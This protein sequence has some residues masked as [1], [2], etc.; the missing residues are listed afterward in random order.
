MKRREWHLRKSKRRIF[1]LL[2][3]GGVEKKNKIFPRWLHWQ[4]WSRAKRLLNLIQSTSVFFSWRFRK[5]VVHASDYNWILEWYRAWKFNVIIETRSY[6]TLRFPV[7]NSSFL[8]SCDVFMHNSCLYS[9]RM[10]IV[11]CVCT[12]NEYI[13]KTVFSIHMY[14]QMYTATLNNIGY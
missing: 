4:T 5:D 13:I 1:R 6:F 8:R 3:W 7:S 14:I 12:R 10:Y 11:L 9:T 2:E